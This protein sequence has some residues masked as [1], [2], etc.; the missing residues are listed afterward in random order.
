VLF[1]DVLIAV[2][3]QNSSCGNKGVIVSSAA[4]QVNIRALL[5]EATITASRRGLKH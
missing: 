1:I 3:K 4:Y 5:E 2:G